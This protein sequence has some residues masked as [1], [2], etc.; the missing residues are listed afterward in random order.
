MLMP[1][2][3]QAP[4]DRS[5]PIVID[6]TGLI[7]YSTTGFTADGYVSLDPT[8]PGTLNPD[9]CHAAER[10]LRRDVHR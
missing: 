6:G 1:E 4:A 5:S 8:V 10:L 2:M 9:L 3:A 7:G